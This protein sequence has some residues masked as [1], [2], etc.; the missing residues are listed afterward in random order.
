[1]S[2]SSPQSGDLNQ[3]SLSE[4]MKPVLEQVVHFIQ[5]EIDPVTATYFAAA[6]KDNRWAL[7][8]E[9]NRILN[10]LKNKAKE[11]GLWNFFLPDWNG[12]GCSNLDYAYLAAEMGKNPLAAEVFNCAAPDTGNMEVLAKYGSPEQQKQWLEPL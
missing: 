2:G 7:S 1:M 10:G 8:T 4:H 11:L 12:E 3:L 6:N 9:Q 5:S